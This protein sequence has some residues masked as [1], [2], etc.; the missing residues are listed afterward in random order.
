MQILTKIAD[1][2]FLSLLWLAFSIPII[3]IGASTTALFYTNNKVIR[4]EH[5]YLWRSFW[6]SFRQNFKQST[7]LWLLLMLVYVILGADYYI[8]GHYYDEQQTL[9]AILIFIGALITLWASFWFPYISRFQDTT[10]TVL[11]N[12]GFIFMANLPISI[13]ILIVFLA[14]LGIAFFVPFSIVI[15]PSIS[16]AI[17]NIFLDRTFE[18]YICK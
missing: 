4:R 12:T 9:I 8:M 6:D 7:F 15:I 1:C 5:G 2:I 11:K 14:S 10:K 18:K 17:A 3:T 16:V 13:G